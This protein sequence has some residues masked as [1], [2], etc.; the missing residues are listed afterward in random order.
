MRSLNAKF[1]KYD[2]INKIYF[3]TDFKIIIVKKKIIINLKNRFFTKCNYY[4]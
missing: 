4:L 3:S 1:Y 2:K